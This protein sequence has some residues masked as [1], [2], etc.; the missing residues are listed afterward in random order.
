MGDSP[1]L[2]LPDTS[3]SQTLHVLWTYICYYNLV[4]IPKI[5]WTGLGCRIISLV[6]SLLPSSLVVFLA[7]TKSSLSGSRHA[8]GTR[9]LAQEGWF[10]PQSLPFSQW[11]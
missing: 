5:I 7:L 6:S 1:S 4:S 9:N 10:L 2:V 3:D 8:R 11:L